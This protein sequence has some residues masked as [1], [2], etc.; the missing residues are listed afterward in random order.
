MEEEEEENIE[1]S[2]ISKYPKEISYDCNKKI[3][4]QME[5]YI[6]KICINENQGTGFFCQIPVPNEN[7]MFHVFITNNHIIDEEFLNK[8]NGKIKL[9]IKDEE[10][11]KKLDLNY[12]KIY[13]NKDYDV[14][15]IEI[16][17]RDDIKNYLELDDII[18]NDILNNKNKIK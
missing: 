10:N 12:R 14:T 13:T 18:I 2:E 16:K 4:E 9:D 1:E 3:L 17:E 11:Y 5:K 6:C 15:I 7:K 8:K